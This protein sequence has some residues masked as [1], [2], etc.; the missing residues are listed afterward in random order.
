M[1]ERCVTLSFR[2]LNAL[3]L[4]KLNEYIVCKDEVKDKIRKRIFGRRE[5][6]SDGAMIDEFLISS[7]P[8]S[9]FDEIE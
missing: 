1:V 4:T 5:E 6:K 9:S 2:I 7:Y 3:L 8:S